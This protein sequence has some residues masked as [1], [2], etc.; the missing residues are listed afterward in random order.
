[1]KTTV[2]ASSEDGVEAMNA[3]ICADV[4]SHRE[5]PGFDGHFSR[6]VLDVHIAFNTAFWREF[7]MAHDDRDELARAVV[8]LFGHLVVGAGRNLMQSQED[9]HFAAWMAAVHRCCQGVHE[10]TKTEAPVGSF[11]K[12]GKA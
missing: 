8:N 9:A 3:K 12:G 2:F 6:L 1:M 5:K 7:D 4:E 11:R 10:Q